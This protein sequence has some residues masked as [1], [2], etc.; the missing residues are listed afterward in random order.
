MGIHVLRERGAGLKLTAHAPVL[1]HGAWVSTATGPVRTDG[2]GE[3]AALVERDER[4]LLMEFLECID[5][6]SRRSARELLSGILSKSREVTGAEAGSIFVAR[7]RGRRRWLEVASLQNDVIKLRPADFVIPV[8]PASIAGYVAETGETLVIDDLYTIPDSKSYRFNPEFDRA[9]GYRS[10][11]M[12]CFPLTNPEGA[13]IGVVQLIN[14]RLEGSIHPMPFTSEQTRLILPFNHVVGAAIERALMLEQIVAK[15]VKLRE[16][17]RELKT[18]RARIEALQSETEEAFMLAINLLALA[19]EIHDKNTAG[20][21]ARTNEYS[22]FIARKLGCSDVFC[23]EIHYSAQM[24]DVGKMSI[25]SALVKKAGLLAP[26]ER[27]E[28]ECHAEYGYRIL[29]HSNRLEMAAELAFA[30]HEKWDGTGYPNGVKGEQIPLAARITAIGDVY[31]AIRSR[32]PYKPAYGH[33]RA[34]AIMLEGDDRIDPQAHFDPTLLAIFAANHG[35][36]DAI[37]RGFNA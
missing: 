31:D 12:L 33:D 32:R 8:N 4:A 36:M 16:R 7:K 6:S 37:W 2:R 23:D 10:C 35:E 5:W 21:I 30:H 20:H 15:N 3:S 17:N 34:C 27:T 9:S 14:R 28:M 19:A 22:F 1:H 24:H 13:V 18:Q 25:D 29:S 11:S 26:E